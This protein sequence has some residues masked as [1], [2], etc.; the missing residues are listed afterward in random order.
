MTRH[1][2]T[3]NVD[4]VMYVNYLQKA[5]ENRLMSEK[6][7][8]ERVFNSAA[9]SAVHCAISAVDAFCV[10]NM[11]KRCSSAGHEDVSVLIKATSYPDEEKTFV[12]GKFKSVIRIKNMAEYE[13]RLV[14]EKEA[15]K[16]VREAGL[17]LD[18]V[19]RALGEG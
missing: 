11:G 19:K 2:D 10:A 18:A 3:K 6:A 5:G 1:V 7:L 12:A 14:K 8:A 15:E 16:A 13:E 4:K 17:L 9:V